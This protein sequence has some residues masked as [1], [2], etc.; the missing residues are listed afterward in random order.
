LANTPGQGNPLARILGAILES[1]AGGQDR[2]NRYSKVVAEEYRTDALL[3]EFPVPNAVVESADLEF[4]M[5]IESVSLPPGGPSTAAAVARDRQFDAIARQ[6]ARQAAEDVAQALEGVADEGGGSLKTAA[7]RLRSKPFVTHLSASLD[8]ALTDARDEI[9][10][11][12]GTIDLEPLRATVRQVL[13]TRLLDHPDI[14]R[15]VGTDTDAGRQLDRR[16]SGIVETAA[17]AAAAPERLGVDLKPRPQIEVAVTAP[18][19][20]GLPPDVLAKVRMKTSFRAFRWVA[21][22]DDD[23]RKTYVLDLED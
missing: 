14:A 5:A 6:V 21:V 4:A 8:D 7:Q 17:Q 18:E 3:R 20:A 19:L 22:A 15:Y 23:G 2:S 13:D 10:G 11:P 16:F 1:F 9:V 12:D